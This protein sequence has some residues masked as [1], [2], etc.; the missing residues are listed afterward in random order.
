MVPLRGGDGDAVEIIPS[1]GVN[2]RLHVLRDA[3]HRLHV[4]V[5]GA[6]I[7]SAVV[8][9]LDGEPGSG[10]RL[11]LRLSRD[12]NGSAR[13]RVSSHRDGYELSCGDECGTELDLDISSDEVTIV[14]R[15][16]DHL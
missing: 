4:L 2:R 16:V 11:D 5:E 1:D 10:E 14:A 12:G 13:V 9:R 15:S 3:L 8:T 6:T 7:V